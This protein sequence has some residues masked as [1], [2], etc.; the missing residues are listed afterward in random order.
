M[1]TGYIGQASEKT[2]SLA[3]KIDQTVEENTN[4]A[5]HVKTRY[6]RKPKSNGHEKRKPYSPC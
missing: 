6:Y 2:E 3:V 5:V 4:P 1:M